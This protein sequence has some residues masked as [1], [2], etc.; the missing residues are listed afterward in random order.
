MKVKNVSCPQCWVIISSEPD[1]PIASIHLSKEEADKWTQEENDRIGCSLYFVVES[2][3]C[4]PK[5]W[6][7]RIS[8]VL[9]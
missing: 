6:F 3:V 4:L 1:Y 7:V 5:H 2:F 9:N 8:P